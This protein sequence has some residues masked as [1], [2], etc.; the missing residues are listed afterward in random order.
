MNSKQLI[1]LALNGLDNFGYQ[2][3]RLGVTSKV[4]RHTLIAFAMAEQKRFEGEMDSINA[5]V[6][7]IRHRAEEGA[8]LVLKPARS[9][10]DSVRGLIGIKA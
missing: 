4:N 6:S 5:R 1:D 8:E 10:Y 3:E 7:Y 2:L 9:A